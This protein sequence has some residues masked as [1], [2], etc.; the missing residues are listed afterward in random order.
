[1]TS[2]SASRL[3]FC[4]SF[5]STRWISET[6]PDLNWLPLTTTTPPD[7]SYP[8]AHS[9]I[10]AGGAAVLSSF[11]GDDEFSFAVRSEVLPGVERSFRSFP[12]AAEEAGLS[13][14]FAG[15]HFRFDH[16]AGKQLG[17]HVA[18]YVVDNF[19]VPRHRQDRESDE[20]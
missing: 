4:N 19:L 9:V 8:G 15:V 2:S 10:S 16:N 17:R 18:D 7:P 11:F 13:R 3:S 12:A 20:R 1:M 14:M 6:V 5:S